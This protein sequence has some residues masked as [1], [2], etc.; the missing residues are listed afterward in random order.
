LLALGYSR[1][2]RRCLAQE[3]VED[4]YRPWEQ[5]MGYDVSVY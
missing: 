5:E 2:T 1:V 3:F 4:K